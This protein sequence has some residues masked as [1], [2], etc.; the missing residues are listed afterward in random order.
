MI[1]EGNPINNAANLDLPHAVN[2]QHAER[3]VVVVVVVVVVVC[4]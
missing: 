4:L 2:H 3:Q 1:P